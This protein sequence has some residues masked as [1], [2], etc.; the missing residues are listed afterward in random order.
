MPGNLITAQQIKVYMQSKKNG[1]KQKIASAQSGLSERSA[2]NIEQRGG[3]RAQTK[4]S[5][6]TRKDPFDLVWNT[7]IT[8]LLEQSPQLQAKT[9]LDDLQ[10]KIIEEIFRGKTYKQ[11][12]DIYDYDEGYIGDE[13]RQLFKIISEYLGQDINKS[14]FCWT[15]ERVTN[16]GILNA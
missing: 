11:I 9:L 2:Y 15:L 14:N 10:K 5:W 16:S 6:R 8:S 12:A 4:H 13:S 7:E 3:I 1:K